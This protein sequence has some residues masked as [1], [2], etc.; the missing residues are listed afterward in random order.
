MSAARKVQAILVTA[1]LVFLVYAAVKMVPPM[2]PSISSPT[3]C[4]RRAVRERDPQQPEPD[5]RHRLQR[6]AGLGYPRH[7]E[8]LVV[9]AEAGKVSISLDYRVPIDL[10]VCKFDL[11]FTPSSAN[12][13]II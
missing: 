12:K 5:Q 6:N 3:R 8:D 10:V 7:E 4:R 1:I 13:D 9:K 11:H 2:C